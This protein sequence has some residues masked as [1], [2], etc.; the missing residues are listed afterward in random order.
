MPAGTLGPEG[1]AGAVA[2]DGIDL[3]AMRGSRRALD[4]RGTDQ[5]TQGDAGADTGL[6]RRP[7][8]G[9]RRR[10]ERGR[11]ARRSTS[12][13]SDRPGRSGSGRNCRSRSKRRPGLDLSRSSWPGRRPHRLGRP[14]WHQGRPSPNRGGRVRVAPPTHR[15]PKAQP[16]LPGQRQLP[17]TAGRVV[18]AGSGPRPARSGQAPP[19]PSAWP[20]TGGRWGAAAGQAPRDRIPQSRLSPRAD[21]LPAPIVDHHQV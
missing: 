8:R 17:R 13:H 6:G 18:E 3:E 10:R 20:P 2:R 16:L 14:R 1:G 19:N 7:R 12:R 11:R 4:R 15:P 9:C 21:A 5:P